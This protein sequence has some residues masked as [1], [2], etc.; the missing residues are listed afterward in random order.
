MPIDRQWNGLKVNLLEG[1]VH[2]ANAQ[3]RVE[4]VL[5]AEGVQ[6]ELV[7]GARCARIRDQQRHRPCICTTALQPGEC[8]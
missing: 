4:A 6:I 3:V 8:P 7:R 5:E 2:T 1:D